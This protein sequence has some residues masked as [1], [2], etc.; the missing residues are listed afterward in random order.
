MSALAAALVWACSSTP[1]EGES[2]SSAIS[3]GGAGCGGEN[4][5]CCATGDRCTGE[6]GCSAG[7]C[8]SVITDT[9]AYAE[10]CKKELGFAN[11]TAKLPYMSCFDS[12]TAEGGRATTGKVADIQLT[13]P[14]A[15][16]PLRLLENGPA[17]HEGKDTWDLVFGAGGSP[18]EGCDNPNYLLGICDPYYR[19]NVWKPDVGGN[20]DIVAALHCRA[21]NSPKPQPSTAVTSEGRKRAYDE[22]P[23]DATP[24]EKQRL[25]DQWNGS[26]EIVL[27]MTNTRTGKACFF[28]AATPYYGSYIPAP[29]DEREVASTE[30]A[31]RVWNELPAKPPHAPTERRD[32]W[33]KNASSAW[34][35]P[36]FM[37]CVGCHDS[38]PFMHNPFIDSMDVLPA[39][40]R[41]R[42]YLPLGYQAQDPPTMI[43]T[44]AV[45][46]GEGSAAQ[47]CTSCH[48]MGN[49]NACGSW[50][51]RAVGWEFPGTASAESKRQTSLSRYMPMDHGHGSTADF[52]AENGKHVDAMKCCCEH[53]DW[54]G[55]RRVPAATPQAE[56][57]AGTATESCIAPTCGG[58]GQACC[59]GN[60][61]NHGGLTCASGTCKFVDE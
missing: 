20:Q 4:Q 26:S 6:L 35:A 38:G 8:K 33:L 58:W 59:E 11:P 36:N 34:R 41:T 13:R 17:V 52:Y 43:K 22:A 47:R 48:S 31:T 45:R 37:R 10:Y 14:G 2:S 27:T 40:R 55:C 60:L 19:L 3:E 28:H 53:P 7:L 49:G 51:N 25:F 16:A 44:D 42:P 24:E 50:F 5:A 29:D 54:R 23:A 57:T 1:L 56:G 61:C 12:P 32:Q 21:S 46:T 30:G 39:D 18:A 15:S 9:V